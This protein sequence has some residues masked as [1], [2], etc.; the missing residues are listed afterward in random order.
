MAKEDYELEDALL[1]E[2]KKGKLLGIKDRLS[3]LKV[4][5][6]KQPGTAGKAIAVIL[7]LIALGIVIWVAI[8]IGS[9]SVSLIGD[10]EREVH[11]PYGNFELDDMEVLIGEQK[12]GSS[13]D[14]EINQL[15]LK[16]KLFLAYDRDNQ[17]LQEALT[18]Y[19]PMIY[20]M[21][22]EIL[23][24]ASINEIIDAEKRQNILVPKIISSINRLIVK[25]Q[26]E[27]YDKYCGSEDER[28]KKMLESEETILEAR[29]CNCD[30]MAEVGVKRIFFEYFQYSPRREY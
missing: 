5:D 21:I 27:D 29:P 7:I 6:I 2:E 20:H 11:K 19:S 10:K 23:S 18:Q 8:E 14:D 1:E 30:G 26:D 15:L 12:P 9:A 13:D 28:Y 25:C 3:G 4:S 24:E 17:D 16:A 22:L